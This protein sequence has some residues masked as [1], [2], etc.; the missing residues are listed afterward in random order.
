MNTLGDIHNKIWFYQ[1]KRWNYNIKNMEM[2]MRINLLSW[3]YQKDQ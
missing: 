3:A 2:K 1:S